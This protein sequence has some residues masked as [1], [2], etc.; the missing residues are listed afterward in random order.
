MFAELGMT[1]S[2]TLAAPAS[3]A[4]GGSSRLGLHLLLAFGLALA[5]TGAVELARHLLA[6]R[7][8]KHA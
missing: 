3:A 6:R 7:R 4:A 1:W 5:V 2:S 8:A